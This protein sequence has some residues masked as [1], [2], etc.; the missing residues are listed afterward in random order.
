MVIVMA[1]RRKE[2]APDYVS[3]F[4][5]GLSWFV[6]G[7]PLQSAGLWMLGFVFMILGL[8]NADA[9]RTTKKKKGIE[10]ER[11]IKSLVALVAALIILL[12]AAA[13]F[14]I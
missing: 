2:K 6:V 14:S 5:V 4:I 3:F 8:A 12:G 10:G 13:F 7:L 9:W 11:V 1:S